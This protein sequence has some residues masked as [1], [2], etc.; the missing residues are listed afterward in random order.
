M[1]DSSTIA[2]FLMMK[3]NYQVSYQ[4]TENPIVSSQSRIENWKKSLG[5]MN[6]VG[7][8]LMDLF[9][10]FDSIPPDLLFA[11]RDVVKHE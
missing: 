8:V 10:V 7:T 1:K 3:Q 2:F 9:K 4:L 6:F 11:K 5:N